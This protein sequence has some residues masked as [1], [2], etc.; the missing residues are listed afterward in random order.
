MPWLVVRD[1]LVRVGDTDT[2]THTADT[3]GAWRPFRKRLQRVPRGE[4][5][6][7]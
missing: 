1:A 4:T 3:P 6:S 2:Y 7:I 5:A